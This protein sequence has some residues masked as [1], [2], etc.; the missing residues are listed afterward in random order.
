MQ[1][2]DAPGAK[3][4]TNPL[5][6]IRQIVRTEGV[7]ALYTGCSTLI[8]GTV[9]KASVRFLSFDSIRNALA[10][11]NGKLG[12]GKGMLAGMTAGCVESLV[13]VTPTERI[14]TALYVPASFMGL[15]TRG[16]RAGIDILCSI[17]DAKSAKRFR[18]V[19]H[20]MPILVREQ[21]LATIY[22]GLISTTI[23]QS[24]TSAARMGSY[25]VL[26][27]TMKS[28]N[29][30]LNSF[31]T[32]GIGSIA[33][34]ITVYSTQPF[35][36]VKTRVQSANGSGMGD[37]VKSILREQ[38]ISGFWRGST[39]RLGRLVFSGGIVFTVYE[40]VVSGLHGMGVGLKKVDR[41]L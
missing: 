31:T 38:G 24:A 7:G 29:L 33:G 3:V 20:A 8:A 32:F 25:N 37:A 41:P 17:D 12:S 5:V 10:D 9:F 28:N 36:T 30:P 23:K 11:E 19:L 6:M 4:T 27:E 18:G 39:M 21:G 1:L 14:K 26:R 40:A 16:K 2:R 35:D 13:A 22:R 34:I 15:F